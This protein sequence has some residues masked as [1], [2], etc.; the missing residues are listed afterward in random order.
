MSDFRRS[1][2]MPAVNYPILGKKRNIKVEFQ[3]REGGRVF[4]IVKN[5][6]LFNL[7]DHFKTPFSAVKL[8]VSLKTVSF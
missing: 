7:L 8:K 1:P 3:R 2:K 6:H 4:A 5:A